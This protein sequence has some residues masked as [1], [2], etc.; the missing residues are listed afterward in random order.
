MQPARPRVLVLGGTGMLGHVLWGEC[1][2]RFD[3][4]ATVRSDEIPRRA[5]GVL[6]PDRTLTGVRLEDEATVAGALDRAAPD[7]VVNCI[8]LVK[9]RPEAADAAALVRAN[10]LFPARARRR[11]RASAARASSTSPRTACSPATGAATP[12]TTGPTRPTST[13]A[14]SSPGSPRARAC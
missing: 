6:D 1:S 11:L 3:A 4:V 14:R 7:V 2:E 8:G 9:Q 5:A 12:R 10:A 13:G